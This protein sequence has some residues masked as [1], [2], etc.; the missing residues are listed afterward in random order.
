MKI[1]TN[2]TW[3]FQALCNHRIQSKEMLEK[4]IT[5]EMFMV[6]CNPRYK[7]I[8]HLVTTSFALLGRQEQ[9]RI[10][11]HHSPHTE[12][13]R[14]VKKE[15]KNDK[16]GDNLKVP[17]NPSKKA[18]QLLQSRM[19]LMMSRENMSNEEIMQSIAIH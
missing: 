13:E 8:R 3:I 15:S 16:A 12:N 6:A 19:H 17:E 1:K 10:K 2:I 18:P 4:S 11:T 14:E 9:E 7:L 5:R